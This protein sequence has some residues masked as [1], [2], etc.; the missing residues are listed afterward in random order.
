MVRTASHLSPLTWTSLS[1]LSGGPTTLPTLSEQKRRQII[2][3][4]TWKYLLIYFFFNTIVTE[5]PSQLGLTG[6]NLH[7]NLYIVN[8]NRKIMENHIGKISP[9]RQIYSYPPKRFKGCKK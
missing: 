8:N 6:T 2:R 1:L 3:G 7:P 9:L 4:K 5:T